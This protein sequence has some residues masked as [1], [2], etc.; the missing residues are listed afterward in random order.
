MLGSVNWSGVLKSIIDTWL[1]L[2]GVIG[3]AIIIVLVIKF[4]KKRKDK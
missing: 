1:P 2:F 3:I 4:H